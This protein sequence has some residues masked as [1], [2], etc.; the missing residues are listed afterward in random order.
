MRLQKIYSLEEFRSL[1]VSDAVLA[2]LE[3]KGFTTPTP[4]QTLTIP[5]L[6][7]GSTDVVAQAQTGTGKTAA[8]GIP[9]IDRAEERAGFVQAIVLTPTRELCMQV[10]SEIDSL[11]GDK[12]LSIVTV[13]GGQSISLQI[14]DLKRGADIVVG[15]PGR[16]IDMLDRGVLKLEGVKYVV[17]DEADEMLNMGFAEDVERI[18][19]SV[20]AD[21]RMLLF[22]A[23]MPPRILQLAKT[24]MGDYQ[25]LVAKRAEMTTAL[26]D[27]VY[28]E[29][30][31]SDKFNALARLIDAET[32]FYGVIFCRTKIETTEL[33]QMLDSRG[34]PSDALHGDVAQAQREKIL[35][36]F[37]DR[38][39]QILVA[40]DVAARGIDVTDLSHV[41][42]FHLPYEPESYVHRI[43]RT[44]R[45]GKQGTA[46]SLVAPG[47]RRLLDIIRKV[48]KVELRKG[49]L[50]SKQEVIQRRLNGLK[51]S[52][53]AALN[54]GGT[55]D[56]KQLAA[57]L[58]EQYSAE[59]TVAALLM[60]SVGPDFVN[61]PD[62]QAAGE[63]KK[64]LAKNQQVGKKWRKPADPP[65][66]G[67][68]PPGRYEQDRSAATDPGGNR[69]PLGPSW[70]D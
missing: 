43:G 1:G 53:I 23:T 15:T 17:L 55:D 10:A 12:K 41:V 40:T 59:D 25:N 50:P 31:P 36:K 49:Q 57:S 16:V 62:I 45:A 20:N 7:N 2:A 19:Q 34:Y 38:K 56:F 13:Y 32:A 70:Q 66:C 29:V 14:K 39:I 60:Q 33:A 28:Y 52:V 64:I 5:L 67:H 6:L 9:V 37:R 46:I 21:R 68:G 3:K 47:E 26:I 11:R 61:M 54:Q 44:G 69:H 18:L 30:R 65:V 42:N 48:T 22:S 8:F 24:Y 35:Q 4:I 51:E 63:R 58:L 27:Q